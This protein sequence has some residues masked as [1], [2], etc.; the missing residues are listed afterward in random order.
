MA[1][2]N[3][4]EFGITNGLNT[5]NVN[6]VQ[7]ILGD[8]D[9]L[10]DE[11]LINLNTLHKNDSP[12]SFRDKIIHQMISILIGQKKPNIILTGPAGCGKT[13]LVEE[14][15]RQLENNNP[16]IP[17]LL[18]GY[19]IFELPLAALTV[20]TEIRG[21]LESKV[22]TLIDFLK[23]PANKAI[24]F[25]DEIHMLFTSGSSLREVSQ[26]LKPALARGQ[27]RLIGA[28]TNQE[29]DELLRDPAF[30]RRFSKIVV[31]ELTKEQTTQILMDLVDNVTAHYQ[32]KVKIKKEYLPYV[33]EMAD[34]YKRPEQHRPDNAITLLDRAMGEAIMAY[35]EEQ[36]LASTTPDEYGIFTFKREFFVT[37]QSI[38]KVAQTLLFGHTTPSKI[39]EQI[40][41]DKFN[42]IYGQEKALKEIKDV[43]KRKDLDLFTSNK[44]L[45]LLFSGPTGTGKTETANILADILFKEKPIIL[46]MA[47]YKDPTSMTKLIGVSAGYVGFDSHQEM[48]LD[49]LES[50]P[51]QVVVLD[52]FEKA[53]NSVQRLFLAALET[54]V[55]KTGRGKQ[56]DF[57]KAIIIATTNAGYSS[58][59]RRSLINTSEVSSNEDLKRLSKCFDIEL[60]NRFSKRITYQPIS[61]DIF[62]EILKNQYLLKRKQL[63]DKADRYKLP[64]SLSNS[65][66]AELTEKNYSQD[67]NARPCQQAIESY[68]EDLILNQMKKNSQP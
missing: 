32:G 27:I 26:H 29:A 15:A 60:I 47:E 28:T 41:S 21:Q 25:I 44:P 37:K 45:S 30:S 61:K 10:L 57:S 49:A 33:V 64:E 46:N 42:R 22:L 2:H 31:D 59:T 54:G 51:Y 39:N 55:M 5:A 18:H 12:L 16:L 8:P 58:D 40:L 62:Q 38:K 34:L 65:K 11:M 6:H 63:G 3:Y 14:I 7:N 66:L 20:G 36:L 1:M 56:I 67:L 48:P 9:S 24:L 52:E 53:C 4:N 17:A 50:N 19:R 13:A 43:L 23:N 35:T 68:M